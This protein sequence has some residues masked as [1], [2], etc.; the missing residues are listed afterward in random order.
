ATPG[1]LLPDEDDVK[2]A[3]SGKDK[4]SQ[5]ERVITA[6]PSLPFNG[7]GSMRRVVTEKSVRLSDKKRKEVAKR[8][9][10][11]NPDDPDVFRSPAVTKQFYKEIEGERIALIVWLNQKE[12]QE[13]YEKDGLKLEGKLKDL[14]INPQ[15]VEEDGGE[16][17][18]KIK[19]IID[20]RCA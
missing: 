13:T 3:Y 16:R 11:E 5:I 4:A 7:S 1:K 17:Y 8:M 10:L 18:A 12:M 15:A 2:R 14:V 19:S 20:T 6:H 9:G